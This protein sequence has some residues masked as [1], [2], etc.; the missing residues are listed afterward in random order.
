MGN[1]AHRKAAMSRS[2]LSRFRR[3]ACS[4]SFALATLMNLG[5]AQAN[6]AEFPLNEEIVMLPVTEN[7][8]RLQLE[9]T[10][11]R[12]PGNGPFPLLLMN[13]GKERGNPTVQKRDR[14]LAMSREFVKRGYAVAVPMR[15]GFAKSS[16]QYSDFGC[17]MKDNGQLQADSLQAALTAL[18]KESW[19]DPDRILVAGQSYGGLATMAFGTRPFPGVRGLLNFAG[20][21]RVDGG[22]CN[23]RASLVSAVADYAAKTTLPSLWFYGENDSYFDHELASQMFQAYQSAGGQAQLIAFG[24][25]KADA[26]GLAGS[27]DGV[28]IWWPETERF[29]QSVGLPTADIVPLAPPPKIAA[30]NFAPIDNINAVPYLT[31]I[32]REGYRRFLEKSTPRAFAVSPSGQ[33]SWAEEGDDP[34]ERVL[35]NCQQSSKAPCRLYAVDEDVVW[36][37]QAPATSTTA[38]SGSSPGPVN[39]ASGK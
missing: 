4:A 8:E 25:F 37:E 31:E 24:Q 16:G 12:P 18:V 6:T 28:A 17:N 23:W 29:L 2:S 13:H 33:W 7:G 36:S 38:R 22:S 20:G 34:A 1:L 3:L 26:H 19:V 9:T 32:G 11:F 27:R 39:Q 21:L 10:I 5:V 14:F 35:A 30:T 15:K